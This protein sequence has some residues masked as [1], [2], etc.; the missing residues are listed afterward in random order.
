MA[1]SLTLVGLMRVSIGPAIRVMLRGWAGLLGLRHDR[2]RR[3]H[4]HAGLADG[5]DVRAGTDR[6][7]EVDH[8][9][10]VFVEAEAAVRPCARR[11]HCASR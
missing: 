9:V 2:R 8:V 10:D 5:D 7:E 11:G 4:L 6:L 1:S 3:Q